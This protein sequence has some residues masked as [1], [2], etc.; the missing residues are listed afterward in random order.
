MAVIL[1]V[2]VAASYGVGDFF[3]GLASRRSPVA[4]VAVSSTTRLPRHS[5]V[6]D[7]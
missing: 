7:R 6:A 5:R 4:A 2:L 1:G 3:G